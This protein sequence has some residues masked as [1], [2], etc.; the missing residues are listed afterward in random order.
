MAIDSDLVK[1]L[2]EKSDQEL[3]GILDTPADWRPEVI[4]FVR[5]ELGRRSI[6]TSQIDQKLADNTRQRV[7]ELQKKSIEPLSFWDTVFTALYGGGLGLF[8]LIFVWPQSSRFK[9]DGFVLKYKKS[10]QIYW[11]A[12]GVRMAIVLL[13]IAYIIIVPAGH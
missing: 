6:S 5:S 12:F 7:E 8:G 10:W 4:D 11:L 1:S 3:I 2:S 13:L 9:S